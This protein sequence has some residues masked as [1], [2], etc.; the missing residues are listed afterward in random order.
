M[1]RNASRSSS[2]TAR[3]RRATGLSP[4]K[5]HEE[6]AISDQDVP[7]YLRAGLKLVI[8]GI[9]PGNRSGAA[10]RHYAWPGNHFWPLLYEAGIIPE[11]VTFADDHRV[12]DWDIGLTNLVDRTTRGVEDLTRAEMAEGAEVLRGK[13]LR[14][15]PLAVCFNGKSIYE[16][17]SGR[18]KVAFGLQ[19]ETL[20]GMLL[21]VVPSSSARTAAYQRDAK[22]AYW[23]DLK[24]IID[25][26]AP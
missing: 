16:V 12:L 8:V 19:Q 15:R 23:R 22:A 4:P 13:L 20:E 11:K 17:F 24:R 9:N 6:T 26:A 7:D 25:E 1:A 21:Y 14:Y 2:S 3:S 10:G 18:K 5:S